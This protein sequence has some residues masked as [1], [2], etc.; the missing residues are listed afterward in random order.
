MPLGPG[1]RARVEFTLL[2]TDLLS[3]ILAQS[4]LDWRQKY[5]VV[6]IT[7]DEGRVITPRKVWIAGFKVKRPDAEHKTDSFHHR[8]CAVD[9]IIY[10]NGDYLTDG[11]HPIWKEID[12]KARSMHPKFGLGISFKD[13][14]HLSYGESE[15]K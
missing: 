3:W 13:S 14:N 2:K 12:Q 7:E 1:A 11:D 4:V 15:G 10:L 5:G 8:G 9:L 6:Q